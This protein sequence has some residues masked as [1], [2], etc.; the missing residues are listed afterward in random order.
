VRHTMMDL[1]LLVRSAGAKLT[2][3]WPALLTLVFAGFT[4][5]LLTQRLG[6]LAGEVAWP[7]G[8]LVHTFAAAALLGAVMFMFRTV[9]R[10]QGWPR[11]TTVLA[12]FLV[13]YITT[14]AF[15]GYQVESALERPV[16]MDVAASA[17]LIA[18]IA[19]RWLLPLWPFVQEQRWAQWLWLG[20]DV[21]WMSLVAFTITTHPLSLWLTELADPVWWVLSAILTV[22]VIPVA[23]LAVGGFAL[24]LRPADAPR[25]VNRAGYPLMLAVCV[26]IA[27]ANLIPLLLWQF[28]R[29][30]IGAQDPASF[31]LPVSGL[32]GAVN[33][34]VGVV[35]VVC[36]VA[37]WLD[38][39]GGQQ[40][41]V[42]GQRAGTHDADG[43]R[44]G[45]GRREEE[46]GYLISV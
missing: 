41:G 17:V 23:W 20:L 29:L 31:W 43:D 3:H 37:A 9:L 14:N 12:P 13:V 21:C 19:L 33:S 18:V 44:L 38:R 39:S 8:V 40:P 7:L 34:L 16:T 27:V 6:Q 2:A 4:A 42:A 35:L 26:V 36:L 30:V 10:A 45:D 22:L 24:G 32:L 1:W 25:L 11:F 28:E 46:N 15:N 5:K